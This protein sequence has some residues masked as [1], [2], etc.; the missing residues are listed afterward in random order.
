MN[1][2]NKV[3][4]MGRIG[5][6]PE[7]RHTAGGKPFCR[8]SFAT[9]RAVKR[10]DDWAEETDWHN[11]VVWDQL[12]ERVNRVLVKGSPAVVEG[13]IQ[14]RTYDDAQGIRRRVVDVVADRV[15]FLPGMGSRRPTDRPAAEVATSVEPEAPVPADL[16]DA[17]ADQTPEV[18]EDVPF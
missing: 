3:F 4:L 17:A 5:T 7:L 11:V 1:G 18:G 8:L 10:G 6:A 13:R 16:D 9:T 2:M 12:A 14:S 15:H